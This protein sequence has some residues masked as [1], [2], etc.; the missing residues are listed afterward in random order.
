MPDIFSKEISPSYKRVDAHM[1]D[2]RDLKLDPE[3]SGRVDPPT[4]E[5]IKKRVD[6]FLNPSVGQLQS[7]LISK[8]D[9]GEPIIIDGHIRWMAAMDIT[10][11]RLGPH[12][13]ASGV[14]GVFKLKC[15]YFVGTPLERFIA[16]VKANI[17]NEPTPGDNAAN[18]AKFVHN[19]QMEKADVAGRIYSRFGLDGKPDVPWIDECLAYSELVPEAKAAVKDGKV[20]PS[21]VSILSKLSKN[22]QRE[23]IKAAD[24]GKVTTAMLKDKP[25]APVAD[26][27]ARVTVTTLKKFWEPLAADRKGSALARL[28]EA[29]LHFLESGDHEAFYRNVLSFLKASIAA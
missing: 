24:G 19:F 26:R 21:Q 16:T 2:P 13:D 6:D 25:D 28:A 7:I 22:A 20:K 8:N 27:K 18:V 29:E 10:S 9:D 17:R 4:P 15:T 1:F 23:K 5:D 12:D 11:K 3:L 14:K